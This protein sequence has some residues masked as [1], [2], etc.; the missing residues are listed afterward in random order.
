[1]RRWRRFAQKAYSG[2][3]IVKIKT[4]RSNFCSRSNVGKTTNNTQP[5]YNHEQRY[6]SRAWLLAVPAQL[7]TRPSFTRKRSFAIANNL[8]SQPTPAAKGDDKDTRDR[9]SQRQR[10]CEVGSYH[11]M[12][13]C[14]PTSRKEPGF[15]SSFYHLCAEGNVLVTNETTMHHGVLLSAPFLLSTSAN[16]STNLTH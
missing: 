7:F 9:R 13:E 11:C 15:V 4:F 3:F 8:N 12:S 16:S 10:R 14:C 2:K 1:M 6:R 5:A